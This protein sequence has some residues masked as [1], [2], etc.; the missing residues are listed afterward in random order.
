[1]RRSRRICGSFLLALLAADSCWLAAAHAQ[2]EPVPESAPPP[3][4]LPESSEP[5]EMLSD[6]PPAVAPQLEPTGPPIR[7]EAALVGLLAFPFSSQADAMALGFAVTYGVGWGEIPILIGLD[8]MS[9][10]NEQSSPAMISASPDQP[11]LLAT[12]AEQNRTFYFDLWTRVQPP[13]WPVRPYV[14]GFIGTKLLQTKYSLAIV[15]QGAT[16]SASDHGWASSVG[17]GAGVDFLGLLGADQAISLTLGFRWLHGA[18][19]T[20]N[21]QTVVDGG[22][23]V[24]KQ[25]EPTNVTIYML[26]ISGRFDLSA[27]D[28]QDAL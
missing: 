8:F 9:A 13:H 7:F 20:I 5:P 15:N 14:E 12:K 27:P 18:E 4:T 24:T 28:N 3:D 1:M 26:G 22:T 19:V 2:P 23:V 21:R 17:F 25:H 11:A 10:G 16:S 6:E